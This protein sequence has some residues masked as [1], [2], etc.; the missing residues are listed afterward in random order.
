[1]VACLGLTPRPRSECVA[2]DVAKTRS[3]TAHASLNEIVQFLNARVWTVWNART[4]GEWCFGTGDT[5][6]LG[7]AAPLLRRRQLGH[8]PHRVLARRSPPTRWIAIE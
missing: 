6:Q 8:R 4:C 3:G 7:R 2:I 5:G 1:M